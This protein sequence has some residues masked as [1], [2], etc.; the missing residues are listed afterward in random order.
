MLW[1]HQHLTYSS[2]TILA[3]SA[4]KLLQLAYMLHNQ[5]LNDIVIH[6]WFAIYLIFKVGDITIPR[7]T[8]GER[9]GRNPREH[10][11]RSTKFLCETSSA[12]FAIKSRKRK[13]TKQSQTVKALIQNRFWQ[14]ETPNFFICLE[15]EIGNKV[16]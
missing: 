15:S 4:P 10:G 9:M 2:Y 14:R 12:S 16:L 6:K 3:D 8:L 13:K 7:V 11:Q 5:L 1:I